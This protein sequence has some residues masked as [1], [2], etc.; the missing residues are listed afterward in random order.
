METNQCYNEV[1][2]KKINEV[3]IVKTRKVQSKLI[4][5]SRMNYIKGGVTKSCGY[6]KKD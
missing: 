2:K 5:V 4:R 6:E 3:V 1:G